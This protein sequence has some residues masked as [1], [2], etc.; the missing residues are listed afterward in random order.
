MFVRDEGSSTSLPEAALIAAARADA[1][2]TVSITGEPILV[3]V[4]RYDHAMP[5]YTVGH[6]ERVAAIDAAMSAW[7]AVTLAGASYRGVGLPDCIAQGQAAARRV[8]ERLGAREA[9]GEPAIA[10]A[11]ARG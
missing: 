2:R 3:R 4:A 6:L 10:A 1:E 7:R 5:R 9:S 8:A 11:V